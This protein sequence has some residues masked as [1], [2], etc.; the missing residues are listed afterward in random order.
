MAIY[1]LEKDNFNGTFVEVQ[2]QDKVLFNRLE[3]AIDHVFQE[4]EKELKKREQCK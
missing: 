2:S 1:R 4:R 3:V